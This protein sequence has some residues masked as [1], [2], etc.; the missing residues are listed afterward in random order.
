LVVRTSSVLVRAALFAVDAALLAAY[1][2]TSSSL[3][4][5]STWWD[6]AFVSFVLIP[7][8]F[9]PVLLVLPLWRAP[10]SRLFVAGLA[11][12]ALAAVLAVAGWDAAADFS[13]LAAVTAIGWWFL[14]FFERAAWVVA[15]AAI[16]PFVDAYSV[17]RGPT[18]HI[19][20][21]QQH[22]F[23]VLSFAFPIPGED[24][25]ANLGMPDL[26][27]FAVFL[28]AAARF[29]LRVAPTWICLTLSFGATLALAVYF[30]L[31]GLPAL[32]LVSLGFLAPNADLLWREVATRRRPPRT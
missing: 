25:S 21:H 6:V 11:F 12:V 27:F 3:W 16:I 23:S 9:L 13:K 8:V 32:P 2:A 15:V 30:D 7:L 29:R 31:S 10:A 22:L 5:A 20:E 24:S 26:L 18:K 28:G 17:W 19:V 1:Y 14:G 4:E